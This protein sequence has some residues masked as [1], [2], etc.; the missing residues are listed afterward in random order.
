MKMLSVECIINLPGDPR[1]CDELV[2]L[3]TSKVVKIGPSYWMKKKQNIMR[4]FFDINYLKIGPL[5]PTQCL[6][7]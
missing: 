1:K 6:D 2:F 5:V 7:Q 3:I 4:F